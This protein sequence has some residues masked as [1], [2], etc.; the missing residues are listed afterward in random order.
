MRNFVA[1]NDFNRAQTHKSA[2][3]Y[4][5]VS[6]HELMD[7]DYDDLGLVYFEEMLEE[8][9]IQLEPFDQEV[10]KWDSPS[11]NHL[12]EKNMTDLKTRIIGTLDIETGGT[13][14]DCGS[15]NILMPTFS[16]VFQDELMSEPLIIAGRLSCREQLFLGAKVSASTLSF[17]MGEALR[18]TSAAGTF[19]KALEED[20]GK[21]TIMVINPLKRENQVSTHNFLS[22]SDALQEVKQVIEGFLEEVGADPKDVR[23]YGNGPQFDMS[24][25]ET[26]S[27]KA[28]S[29]N[30]GRAIVP[31]KFWDVGSARNPK[32]YFNAL[33]GDH[34]AVEADA[35]VWATNVIERFNLI[36]H[37][38]T[39]AK[40]DP[41]FD[42][43]AESYCIKYVESL[44]K[45]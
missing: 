1:K 15:T 33:G 38:V 18:G 13:P 2:R 28:N 32:D 21:A 22:N 12:K 16:F 24:I 31:W 39:P 3:D 35:Y 25:Y 19:Q 17:W 37:G 40:H 29:Y 42:A 27:A 9:I 8:H 30:L 45:I 44:L 26:V 41:T 5:R 11:R 43:L 14:G 6:K 34:K 4:S 20:S 7:I 23:F 10:S 36:N